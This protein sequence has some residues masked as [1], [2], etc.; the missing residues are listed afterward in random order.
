MKSN[1]ELVIV[2]SGSQVSAP[3]S[4]LTSGVAKVVELSINSGAVIK[5]D[6]TAVVWGYLSSPPPLTD[7]VDIIPRQGAA[8]TST[9]Q[10]IAWGPI[11]QEASKYGPELA[12]GVRQIAPFA[13]S[14][15]SCVAAVTSTGRV[16]F[17]YDSPPDALRY[18][19]GKYDTFLRSGIVRVESTRYK[20]AAYKADGRA[21]I[22]CPQGGNMSPVI[23]PARVTQVAGNGLACGG[24]AALTDRGEVY[25]QPMS[26]SAG[27][28]LRM[29][30]NTVAVG[31]IG[32]YCFW[33][34]LRDKG[35]SIF[36]GGTGTMCGDNDVRP[37]IR[38]KVIAVASTRY[39]GVAIGDPPLPSNEPSPVQSPV[40]SP[41]DVGTADDDD[42]GETAPSPS[43]GSPGGNQSS[44]GAGNGLNQASVVALSVSIT[45]L[46]MV[47][48][49][50]AMNYAGCFRGGSGSRGA[51]TTS[52]RGG[53][54]L[55]GD[56]GSMQINPI[57]GTA[58]AGHPIGGASG[59]AAGGVPSAAAAQI[60][61][62]AD[63]ELS[64]VSADGSGGREGDHT[65]HR[66]ANGAHSAIHE[67]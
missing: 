34:A 46:A 2:A 54:P 52:R 4:Q 37:D 50:F 16:I 43:P 21:L 40:A 42:G 39:I 23:V 12:S 22:V 8:R 53:A 27:S 9:G 6:G 62:A 61:A 65:R 17:L 11:E 20:F 55:G 25:T 1:G 45:A 38:S 64:D 59:A 33:A 41:G 63:V 5:Q 29:W 47:G 44:D 48:A 3:F 67:A 15:R 57:L 31:P 10:V 28:W 30:R 26:L 7:V 51:F 56:G 58:T 32:E 36:G 18:I 60:G 35:I 24:V 13:E 49:G 66:G 19:S 14:F